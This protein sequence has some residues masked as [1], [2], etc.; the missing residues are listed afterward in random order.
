MYPGSCCTEWASME[1]MLW[2]PLC[3]KVI[4]LLRNILKSRNLIEKLNDLRYQLVFLKTR[5]YIPVGY[6]K[7]RLYFAPLANIPC[8][9]YTL[10]KRGK[11]HFTDFHFFFSSNKI[12]K[13]HF[14]DFI[15]HDHRPTLP[16]SNP[17]KYFNKLFRNK[18]C[19]LT[20]NKMT[21]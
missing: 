16:L 5:K 8:I 14:T 7:I 9:H 10:T 17:R 20:R 2:N 4:F 11:D 15:L 21:K 19:Y 1:N 18:T 13:D 12:H 6:E 3:L